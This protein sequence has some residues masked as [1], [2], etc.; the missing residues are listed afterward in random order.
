[1][2]PDSPCRIAPHV[3]VVGGPEITDPADGLVYAVDGG[4]EIALVDCG[5][6]GSVPRILEN[7][8]LVG[9]NPERIGLLVLTHRH[10]DHVGGAP[11]LADRFS[12]R[13]AC[14]HLD[15]EALEAADPVS[16]AASWYGVDLPSIR[17]DERL[18]GRGG[19]L[20]VGDRVLGWIHTPGHTPGSVAV[21]LDTPEGRVVFAHDVHG[22]FLSQFGSDIDRWAESMERL[23]A[24]GP[25]ILCEGHFGVFR[26][27]GAVERFV[28]DHLRAR[29][30]GP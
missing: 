27:R 3:Y 15:A 18:E 14:H 1:M 4:S 9:L 2:V 13:I 21:Y 19:S 6:G 5:A 24:L 17:V 12:P 7:V 10:V 29:G 25:D 23:L 22:P 16:T 30:Y 11:A 28:R 26:P 20:T 8:R